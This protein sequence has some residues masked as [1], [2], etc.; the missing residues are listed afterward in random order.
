MNVKKQK[1][2]PKVRELQQRLRA[3]RTRQG[4][5]RK[6]GVVPT[7]KQSKPLPYKMQN[8]FEKALKGVPGGGIVGMIGAAKTGTRV[9]KEPLG[10]LRSARNANTTQGYYNRIE[11]VDESGATVVDR[12][13]RRTFG[14]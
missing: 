5:L 8:T 14:R 3:L 11:E 2:D 13:G 4:E 10:L 6:T 9:R 1:V 12:Q 7:K